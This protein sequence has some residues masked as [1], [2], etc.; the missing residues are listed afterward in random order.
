M[1]MKRNI[2]VAKAPMSNISPTTPPPVPTKPMVE[3]APSAPPPSPPKSSPEKTNPFVNVSQGK[4]SKLA[5]LDASG[6][7]NYVVVPSPTVGSFR[8]GRII[9]G[10]KQPPVC[11]EIF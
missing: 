11:K 6:T 9:K 7:N 4:S 2:G 10:K 8:R 3:A 5:A 1:H